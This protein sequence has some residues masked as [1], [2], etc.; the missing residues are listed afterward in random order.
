MF[1]S[2]MQYKVDVEAFLQCEATLAIF[3]GSILC[4][5]DMFC[6]VCTV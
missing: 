1:C 5:V 2:S 3:R 6:D 4:E